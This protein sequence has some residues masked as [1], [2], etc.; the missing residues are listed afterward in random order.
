MA[1][2]QWGNLVKMFQLVDGPRLLLAMWDWMVWGLLITLGILAGALMGWSWWLLPVYP[3]GA[4]CC[5]LIH[6]PLYQVWAENVC[7]YV[8]IFD[9]PQ[10]VNVRRV[11]TPC[12]ERHCGPVA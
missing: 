7:G 5:Y 11:Y 2:P 10:G 9:D 6:E 1:S 8:D 12:L 4:I 3:F